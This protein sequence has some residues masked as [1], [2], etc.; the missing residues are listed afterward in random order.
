[1]IP[2]CLQELEKWSHRNFVL[3]PSPSARD[4]TV[5][6][7]IADIPTPPH[8][9][10]RFLTGQL[11]KAI[12]ATY[13]VVLMYT[14]HVW[15][16]FSRLW[17]QLQEVARQA[18]AIAARLIQKYLPIFKAVWHI[19]IVWQQLLYAHGQTPYSHPV[20]AL[21]GLQLVRQNKIRTP[22]P[23]P[24]VSTLD[25][26]NASGNS[27]RSFSG[28]QETTLTTFQSIQSASSSR[29]TGSTVGTNSSASANSNSWK[30][31][32][33]MTFFMSLKMA[34]MFA[35]LRRNPQE[36][37]AQFGQIGP[38]KRRTVPKPPKRPE[39]RKGSRGLQPPDDPR[40]CPLC[41]EERV[42]PCAST[43]GYVYCYQC[44]FDYLRGGED[45]P[46]NNV[47]PVSGIPCEFTDLI[48][49]Y[50]EQI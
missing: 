39:I 28:K 38:P 29:S 31:L 10:S 7:A 48:R 46:P 3:S 34:N 40:Q 17:R 21:L 36:Y 24:N 33:I 35:S 42:H 41:L 12:H 18:P 37:T 44:I 4:P 9:Q 5:D 25:A 15:K 1:M 45:G 27:L 20:L 2:Y 49:L 22:Q 47:C 8:A 30:S 32:A 23:R 14:S 19:M 16:L 26:S 13:R 6:I 43:G 50:E 11:P